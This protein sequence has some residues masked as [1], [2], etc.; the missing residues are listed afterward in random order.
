MP[1]ANGAYTYLELVNK[2]KREAGIAGGVA[3][4]SLASAVGDTLKVVGW[5][6]DAYREIQQL[7]HNWRWLRK[8]AL[9]DVSGAALSYS[10]DALLGVSAG[11]TRFSRWVRPS[12]NYRPTAY[13]ASNPGTEWALTW[14]PYDRFRL[15]FMIGTHTPGAPQYWSVA[16]D[17][18]LLV[19]PTPDQAYKLRADYYASPQLLSADGDL[20]EMP[21]EFHLLIAWRALG[22]YGAFD[23]APEVLARASSNY[24]TMLNRL[25]QQEGEPITWGY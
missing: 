7:P 19:G 5:V 2:V 17:G 15:A 12:T 10:I 25:I 8:S 4:G 9:G 16:N 6:P 13:L 14:L 21:A 22:E 3:L 11:T 24:E 20:P 1:T 18:A 23:A